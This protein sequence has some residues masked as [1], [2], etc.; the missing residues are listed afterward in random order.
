MVAW[1]A[2]EQIG[3]FEMGEAWFGRLATCGSLA[4]LHAKVG[5]V[6]EIKEGAWHMVVT[7]KAKVHLAWHMQGRKGRK[8]KRSSVNRYI[9][10]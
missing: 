9:Y 1:D 7:V 8:R 6:V 3:E 5:D 4:V 10:I 2:A